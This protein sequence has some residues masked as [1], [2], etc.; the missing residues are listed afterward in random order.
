VI[1]DDD[2][3]EEEMEDSQPFLNSPFPTKH[4]L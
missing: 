2:D 3:E 1:N 4:D